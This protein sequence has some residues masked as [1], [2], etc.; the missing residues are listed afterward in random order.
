ML[1]MVRNRRA[2]FTLI[3]LL[4]VIAVVA[5]VMAIAVPNMRTF[6]LNNRLTAGV[7]DLLH[8]V[9]LARTEAVKRQAN[10]V[11]CGTANVA[12]ADAALRC[13]YNSFQGWFVFVDNSPATGGNWQH[14]ADEPVIERHGLLDGTITVKTDVGS[15]ILSYGPSGFSTLAPGGL[16]VNPTG[17]LVL[18][19]SRGVKQVGTGATATATARAFLV[20]NTGRARASAGWNDVSTV[21][22]PLVGGA[23]P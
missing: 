11:V 19:D 3:E 5:I 18:C 20:T 7:N 8:S 12:V 1:P 10:V 17:A 14:E 15:D 2:G 4:T 6:I 23:C 16:G 22:L 9:N 13:S 21:A